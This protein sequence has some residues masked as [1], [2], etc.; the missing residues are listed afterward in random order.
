[1]KEKPTNIEE[2]VNRVNFEILKKLLCR[3]II[4]DVGRK[5]PK[6]ITVTVVDDGLCYKP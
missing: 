3:R 5:S 2:E 4:Y 6:V 1:M